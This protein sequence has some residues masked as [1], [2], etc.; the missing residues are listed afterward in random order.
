FRTRRRGRFRKMTAPSVGEIIENAAIQRALESA[1]ADSSA[2]DPLLRH[3]EGGWIYVQENSGKMLTLR[4][5]SGAQA[6]IDLRNPPT[7]AGSFVVATF[8]THP[9]PTQFGWEPCPSEEDTH[10]ALLLGVPCIIR[11]DDGIY[12]T[13]PESR[14]GGLRGNPGF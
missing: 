1:R 3:E 14:R 9:N 4:A 12:N 2:D 7:I 5:E 8:H 6:T 11:A 10:S 13:G